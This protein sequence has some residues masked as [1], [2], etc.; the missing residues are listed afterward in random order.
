MIEMPFPPETVL[1]ADSFHH[2]S[3]KIKK[4]ITERPKSK[5]KVIMKIGEDGSEKRA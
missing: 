1:T 3:L 5:S 2:L 4:K